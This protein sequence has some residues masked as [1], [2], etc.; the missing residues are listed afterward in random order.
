MKAMDMVA[1][2]KLQKI[3][4]RL[5]AVRPFTTEAKKVLTDILDE[6]AKKSVYYLPRKVKH[7]AYIMMT[8]DRGL[9]GSHNTNLVE[10]VLAHIDTGKNEQIIAVGLKGHEHIAARGKNILRTFP[11]VSEMVFY[12]DAI[13]IANYVLSLY[14]S[15]ETDEVYI[16]YTQ[17]KSALTHVPRIIR[18]LPLRIRN[19]ATP[20]ANE[21]I[22][23]PDIISF[24][25]HTIPM[26]LSA[27]VYTGLI[28]SSACEQAARM[29]N[30]ESAVNNASDIIDK[31]TRMY[32][33]KR[34]SAITQEISEIVGSANIMKK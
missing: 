11:D 18:I 24:L 15:G 25:N 4:E 19:T 23:E 1:A 13:Q 28:E 34:Q 12:A 27:S 6:D 17:F 31:L 20:R 7:T 2:A 30:M 9:C 3:R 32:N 5:K 10:K 26:F 14:I 21:M 16:A 8:S 29:I 22:Y 33:R